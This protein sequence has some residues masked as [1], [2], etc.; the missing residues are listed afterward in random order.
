MRSAIRLEL[1]LDLGLA[2]SA[3]LSVRYSNLQY[4]WEFLLRKS[5]GNSGYVGGGMS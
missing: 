4:G 3:T 1:Y 5:G 2:G